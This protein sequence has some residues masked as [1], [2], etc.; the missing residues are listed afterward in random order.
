MGPW[1]DAGY[2]PNHRYWKVT[3]TAANLPPMRVTTPV[4]LLNFGEY[5]LLVGSGTGAVAVGPAYLL[6]PV[7]SGSASLAGPWLRFQ[8]PPLRTQRA[9]LP[10][11][12]LLQASGQ[13][14]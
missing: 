9:D 7:S 6:L 8:L 3:L 5:A 13:G 11:Y 10:H 2:R 14:L 4:E 1:S 12:A